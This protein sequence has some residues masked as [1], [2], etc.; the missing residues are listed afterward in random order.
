MADLRKIGL[1]MREWR[2]REL[3]SF[4]ISQQGQGHVLHSTWADHV[5]A[6]SMKINQR[7]GP[8]RRIRNLLP[9]QA[10]NA[11]YNA[12]ILPLFDYGDVI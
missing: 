8:I 9:L 10:R 1:K 6:I 2:F 11:L 7:I 5:D 3:I 12:L 4:Q